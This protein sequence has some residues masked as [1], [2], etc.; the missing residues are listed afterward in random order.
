MCFMQYLKQQ[1]GDEEEG[2]GK[3]EGA[4]EEAVHNEDTHTI[5]QGVGSLVISS[6]TSDYYTHALG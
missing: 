2:E 1:T 6:L 4:E 5:K 3:G